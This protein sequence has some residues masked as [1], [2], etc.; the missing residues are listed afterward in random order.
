MSD[1]LVRRHGLESFLAEPAAMPSGDAGATLTVRGDL[2]HI[3]L[4]GRASDDAFLRSA[5]QA[6]GQA[7][8]VEPNT[9]ST[10]QH[11]V[12]WLGPDEWLVVTPVAGAAELA[13]RLEQ[14][15]A[16]VH[17]AVN[18]VSGGQI[19]LI[20]RGAKCR[21]LLARGC[22]LDLH[23]REFKPGDCAQSG[24]AKANILIASLDDAPTFMLIVRRSFSD[25]LCRWLAH[26]GS[27]AGIV[28]DTA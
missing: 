27:D 12:C 25:Y 18:D 6:L 16:P 9:F 15:L 7:L 13:G 24:L 20:L 14:A 26:S 8:P 19:A 21:E 23:P 22:T 11:H 1:S 4:R 28:F 2:G 5:E 17:A 10:G 3:N